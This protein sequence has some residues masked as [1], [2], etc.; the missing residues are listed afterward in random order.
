MPGRPMLPLG[1]RGTRCALPPCARPLTVVTVVH[2][3][4]LQFRIQ[5]PQMPS[6][7][8][9]VQPSGQLACQ[10]SKYLLTW[11]QDCLA[12]AAALSKALGVAPGE[13]LLLSTGVIGRRIKMEPLLESIPK[14]AAAL[15]DTAAAAHHAAVAITTTD[16]VSKSAA[17]EVGLLAAPPW[18]CGVTLCVSGMQAQAACC[19]LHVPS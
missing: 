19:E 13:V 16:L 10:S 6:V 2:N 4:Q 11:S 8:M 9:D 3:F 12:S 15:E 1:T 17:L 14:I 18:H 5:N 7:S